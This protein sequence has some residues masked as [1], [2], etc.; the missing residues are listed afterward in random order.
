MIWR[1]PSRTRSLQLAS[2][3]LHAL[4]SS[5]LDLAKI[6]S[7]KLLLD[8]SAVPI[9][10]LLREV[11][12]S[13][14]PTFLAHGNT[15][16]LALSSTITQATTF[17]TDNLKLRQI[18]INLLN[19]A[20]KYTHDARVQVRAWSEASAITIEVMD[21]GVGMSEQTLAKIWEEFVQADE[22]ALSQNGGTGLGLALVKRLTHLLGGSIA[23]T[24]ALG[25]GTTF[26]LTFPHTFAPSLDDLPPDTWPEVPPTRATGLAGETSSV[27]KLSS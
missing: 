19:N 5:T 22:T 13:L 9:A 26:T 15:L 8:V 11:T 18:L 25:V 16:E 3:H 2:N 1:P 14:Q 23:V 20:A 24:S 10:A 21:E 6:E 4:V 27:G 7:G 12:R 17:E